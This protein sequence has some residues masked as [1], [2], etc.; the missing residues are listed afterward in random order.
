MQAGWELLAPA[1]LLNREMP[2]L[3][4]ISALAFLTQRHIWEQ[5]ALK[6]GLF[7]SRC[8]A[9]PLMPV[10]HFNEFTQS[11]PR[12]L[13][14]LRIKRCKNPCQLPA[15]GSLD[16]SHRLSAGGCTRNEVMATGEAGAMPPAPSTTAAPVP[17]APARVQIPGTVLQR[18]KG[19][20]G[21]SKAHVLMGFAAGGCCSHAGSE[22]NI[23]RVVLGS[24]KK[25][26]AWRTYF[27]IFHT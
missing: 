4:V 24:L 2:T 18:H 13:G 17:G 21:L 16:E 7:S 11:L 9:L 23:W 1:D 19:A 20:R 8:L 25:F 15:W 14:G 5:T 22:S 12:L 26:P 6:P 10:L 3:A 27:Y